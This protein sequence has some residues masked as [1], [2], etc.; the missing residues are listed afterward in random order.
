MKLL[1]PRKY[2]KQIFIIFLC[3]FTLASCNHKPDTTDDVSPKEVCIWSNGEWTTDWMRLY[4]D[5]AHG[6]DVFYT[7]KRI[8]DIWRR[9][10]LAYIDD[11]T[12][13]EMVFLC[14]CEAQGNKVLTINNGQVVEWNSFRCAAAYI[15]KSG[16]IENDNGSMGTYWYRIFR[17]KKGNFTELYTRYDME[18]WDYRDSCYVYYLETR[19][20]RTDSPDEYNRYSDDSIP[21]ALYKSIGE[22]IE[23]D[24]IDNYLSTDLFAPNIQ[25]TL[26]DGVNKIT[27]TVR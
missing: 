6:Y 14:A 20:T 1:K 12:I 4:V 25:P 23:F 2:M 17:L 8:M 9:W 10:T 26:P 13:P 27:L 7:D 24:A 15:P 5:Y 18:G 3:V 22:N 21:Q 11:D 19:Y 16:L